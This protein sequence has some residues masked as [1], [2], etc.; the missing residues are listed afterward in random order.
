MNETPTT[1]RKGGAQPENTNSVRHG[2][3]AGKL[4]GHLEY[5]EKRVNKQRRELEA[6]VIARK[7]DVSVMDAAAINSVLKWER[8]GV[9]ANHWLR[10]Q[11][12][13]LSAADKLKFSEAVAKASDNRDRA[14]AKLK[15][16]ID[17]G[18]AGFVFVAGGE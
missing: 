16:D 6:L 11:D 4:P 17:D 5:I 18:F 13:T 3:Y 9:L 1:E 12:A 15:L 2:F 7:G 14:L 8:H 10:E